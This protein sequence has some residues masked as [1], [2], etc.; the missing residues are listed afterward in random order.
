MFIFELVIALLL[1]G[2]IL[3]LWAERVGVPYPALLAFAGA[4]LALVP[5]MPEVALDPDL[6]LALFVAPTL[7]DAAYD[8]SPRDLRD[9][10]VPV[11]SLA[12][13]AVAVTIAAVAW[14]AHAVM[15]DVG[16][17]VAITLGAIVSPPDAS[18]AAAILRRL[19]LPHR[20]T[21]ILEGESLF[22]DAAALLV[23]RLAVGATLTGSFSGWTVLPM[24]VLTAGGSI[25]AG[26]LLARLFVKFLAGISHVS[27]SVLLQFISTFAV[28]I[29]A[30]RVGLSPII[31]VVCYAMTIARRA[32]VEG[33]AR[34]R[35]VSFA[36]WEVVVFVLNVLAFVLI[37]LQL[38]TILSR[39]DLSQWQAFGL[40]AGSVCATVVLVRIVWWMAHNTFSRWRIRRAGQPPAG[41]KGMHPTVGTGLI[42]S[43]CGMRG[44]VSIAAALALP[45]QFPH[46]DLI[47]LCA[48]CVVF[49]TLVVQGLTLRWLIGAVEVPK[50]TTVEREVGLARA[51]TARV[52]LR[53]L[54]TDAAGAK[55][56]RREYE[57]RL[58]S[59]EKQAAGGKPD[60]APP[61]SSMQREAVET[62]R[63]VLLD[64][65]ARE[66]IGDAAFQAAQEELDL[67]ELTADPRLRSN[68]R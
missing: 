4:A 59:G 57:S 25:A 18:A 16:W 2:A 9:N 10:L 35:I 65:R 37:G 58:A 24:L 44:I 22:N 31:A 19:Q 62:Q 47:V 8:A 20:M 3:S 29:I 26:I 23:Y 6:A 32:P 63:Q 49:S 42:I 67:L 54:G 39:L 5:G 12:L 53:T 11:V 48:F 51:E 43:W 61:V 21:V 40:F 28:W 1:V 17:A 52:A 68:E 60:P 27:V 36:V 66:V 41:R 45:L 13:G 50:D 46:R 56:L 38:R 34:K 14:I 7:L 30:D 64:L 15:P 33:D 55:A